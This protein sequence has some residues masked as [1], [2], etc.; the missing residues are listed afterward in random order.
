MCIRDSFVTFASLLGFSI[1]AADQFPESLKKLFN[2][3]IAGFKF[4]DVVKIVSILIVIAEMIRYTNANRNAGSESSPATIGVF[5][6]IIAL[7]GV[8]TVPE[9]FQR[10]KTTDF[11]L[12]GLT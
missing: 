5:V 1:P 4:W 10:L 3:G 12:Q 11:N 9:L 2:G 6:L 8:V 7:L